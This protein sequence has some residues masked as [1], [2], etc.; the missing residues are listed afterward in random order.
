MRDMAL[1][2]T[3]QRNDPHIHIY[4]LRDMARAVARYGLARAA[5]DRGTKKAPVVGDRRRGGGGSGLYLPVSADYDIFSTLEPVRA[6]ARGPD[7]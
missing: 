1:H 6:D 4:G 7:P 3:I 5:W 2:G